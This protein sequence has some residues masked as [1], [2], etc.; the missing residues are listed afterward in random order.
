MTGRKFILTTIREYLNESND[1]NIPPIDKHGKNVVY[2][3]GYLLIT[4]NDV[5]DAKYIALWDMEKE[6]GRKKVGFLIFGDLISYNGGRYRRVDSIEID[7]NYR[8]RGKGYGLKL[9]QYGLKY[10]RK[11]IN[12]IFSYIPDRRNEKQIP[13]IYK[14]LNVIKSDNDDYI[15]VDRVIP[16]MYEC[17]NEYQLLNESWYH[18]TA[19]AR[20]IE[21][22]GGFTHRT[23]T[24]DY[25]KDPVAFKELQIK[26][27]TTRESG[28]MNLYHKLLDKVSDYKMDFT[29][30]KPLFLSDKHAVA[31]TY[32]DPHR[33]FDYQNS[34]QKVY[35]VDVKNCE[36]VAK[37]I[38]FGD[39]F[40]FISIDKVKQG[41]MNSGV[42]EEEIDKLISMFNY[43]IFEN[44]GVRTDVIAA[45][46]SWLGFDCIDVVGVLDSYNGGKITST[47]RMVLDPS[48]VKIK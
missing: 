7:D 3:D 13:S 42:P 16:T 34:V 30:K 25:V 20:E 19:D 36:K 40:R 22:I 5:N 10:L 4:V 27:N 43:Y 15:Y 17:L 46:G 37:I 23:V 24:V 44:K 41:F 45:I 26:L 8:Y 12:G 38:A 35:E 2:D 48:N 39:R 29:Y 28:D 1:N 32:A 18:G 21:K 14:K 11:D 9:Y 47:V 31:K 33:A 6:D